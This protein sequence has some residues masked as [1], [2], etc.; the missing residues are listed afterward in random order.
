MPPIEKAAVKKQRAQRGTRETPSIQSLDRGLVILEAVGKSNGAV[1]LGELTEL[2]AIDRSSAFRLANTLKR[3]GFLAIS[4]RDKGYI[5]GP[6]IWRL[7][8]L[9]DWSNMLVT[10]SHEP[11]KKLAMRTNETAHLAVREGRR[12]FFIGHATVNHM[13]AVAARTGEAV[14]LHCTAHGKALLADC[15]APDL[16][17]L[18]GP[19][20]LQK[21]TPQTVTSRERLAKVCAEIKRRGYATDDAEYQEGIRCVAAPIRDKDGEVIASIGISAPATRFPRER[22]AECAAQVMEV[23]NTISETIAGQKD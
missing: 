5:L 12:A 2:L 4:N 22:Y 15:G 21:Y 23:A 16:K 19:K 17:T 18:F 9:Y 1:T 3:R 10:I 20:D 13:I 8:R 7:S 6:S 14:P 11:L